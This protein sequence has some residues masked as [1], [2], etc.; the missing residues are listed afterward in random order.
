[1]TLHKH[2]RGRVSK[3]V[4]G[5]VGTWLPSAALRSFCSFSCYSFRFPEALVAAAA[6]AAELVN[7]HFGKE[8]EGGRARVGCTHTHT[9]TRS[10]GRCPAAS[11]VAPDR[12]L[13][14]V[15][16]PGCA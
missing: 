12:S 11:P 14:A 9:H 10:V 5:A 3:L 6:R 4:G 13:P 8:R 7:E 2:P 15:P 16:V 1:M